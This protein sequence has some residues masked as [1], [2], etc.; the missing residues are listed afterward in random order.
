MKYITFERQ[1]SPFKIFSID[2]I[3][4]KD[5]E[6]DTRRLVEWQ[7]KHY[8]EKIINRWY[9]F[10]DVELS[11]RLLFLIAN[12][13][14]APSYIS[15]ESALSWHGLIPEGVFSITS[16]T[17]KKTKTFHTLQGAFI[18]HHLKPQLHFGYRLERID[19]Q[20]FKMAELEKVLLD[21]LY[22]HSEMKAEDDFEAWRI[23]TDQLSRELDR[24]KLEKYLFLFSNKALTERVES[25]LK[26]V[27][28]AE[29]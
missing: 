2:D 19:N 10:T 28:N 20:V 12:R 14:Y 13:M 18:Y 8:I 3:R 24:E 4:K 15:F 23:N 9:L 26:Y 17:S 27:E 11:E 25:L 16:A 1:L 5:P 29:S 21:Y 22:L 6:F 7:H